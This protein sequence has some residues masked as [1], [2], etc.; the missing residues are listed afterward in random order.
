MNDELNGDEFKYMHIV[1][2]LNEQYNNRNRLDSIYGLVFIL[3]E[4]MII[5]AASITILLLLSLSLLD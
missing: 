5:V 2:H 3:I 1:F 4:C